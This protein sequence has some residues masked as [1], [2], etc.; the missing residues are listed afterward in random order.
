M[1][2]REL[3]EKY[4][5]FFES[6]GHTQF[7]SGSLIP[8]DVTGRLDE[9]LLF[10]GAG[11]IQFKPY[12]RGAA[13]PTN[14]RLTT[15]QKCVRTGDIE[16]V[17]DDTH[18]TFFEM[19]GNFSFGDYFK[20]EAIR[21]SW[22]FLTSPDWLGLNPARLS[23]TV[24]EADDEAERTWQSC[25]ARHV[26]RL[27]EE[28]NY[29]PAGAFTF[30]PP[31]PCGPNSEMFY[32]IPSDEA[33]P[34]AGY[35][36]DQW[37]KDEA[38]G[39]WVEIWNDVFIQYEW[40]GVA[41]PDTKGYEKTG[42]PE[43]P[44]R[45]I[46][47]GM[48]L[49]RTA[50]VLGG[51]RTVYDTDA[52]APIFVRIAARQGE[53]EATQHAV[54]VAKRVIADHIRTATFC[55]ADGILP[56]NNGRGYVLRRLIRRAILKGERVLK[57]HEAF[58]SEIA[59]GVIESMSVAYPELLERKAVISE[60]LRNE[61]DLFRKTLATGVELLNEELE[62]TNSILDGA[63]AFKL[64][65]T[66]GFPLEVTQELCRERGILVNQDGYDS[67]LKEQQTRSRGAQNLDTVYGGVSVTEEIAMPNAPAESYFFGYSGLQGMGRVVRQ[68][69]QSGKVFVALDRTPFYAESGGQVGD[70]GWIETPVGDFEVTNTTKI[71]RTFW[72][73]LNAEVDNPPKLL[74]E[75]VRASVDVLRRHRIQRNHTATH[76]LHAALRST[77]GT[78]VTQAGSF[79]GP[80]Y[81]RFDFTHGKPLTP[82]Q[83]EAVD[84]IVNRELLSNT[85]VTTYEDLPIDEARA[86]GA[87]A[88]FGEKYGDRVRMV[89]I[90]DFSRELCGG[91]H[92]RTTG[93]IGQFR[94]LSEAS[95]ASGIRRIEAVTGETALE[96]AKQERERLK[97]AAELLKVQ[98]NE[99]L[100]GIE[101]TIDQL[102]QERRKR[103]QIE[104]ELLKSGGANSETIHVEGISLWISNL[105]MIDPK[106]GNSMV[107]EEAA[108]KPNQ[109]TLAAILSEDKV[110]FQCRV[111]T[112]AVQRGAH[113]GNLVKAV[114]AVANGGGGGK[115]E[116][117]SAGGKDVSKVEEALRL[118]ESIL[119]AQ[120]TR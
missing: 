43:L 36:R 19:L 54:L 21:F 85:D 86:K 108:D 13:R 38:A 94:V 41:N 46:D 92:V 63:V 49:E 79:V 51:Y 17:G 32:W 109:V 96:M 8:Y 91:I 81:L 112:E 26:F 116:Y 59:E 1:T 50:F 35:T 62:R 110:T 29:W 103:S 28:T 45:S 6:K 47:T 78:H 102:K 37:L 93:E 34:S 72:H 106:V 55:I 65:D 83:L 18:L 115:A 88:L 60:T 4:I 56:S 87:M 30:G 3:R 27:G 64:Y 68:K 53:T 82:E 84:A 118:A 57:I 111:G 23:F 16:E 117:A 75:S 24:F 120:V 74:E 104:M 14:P 89:E 42:M 52:F 2:V 114:A 67:A 95:A 39:K 10:N 22:E 25:G 12:F 73:E 105:G 101:R 119:R 69:I 48:G 90:G 107:D 77:L 40:Q 44:F 7:P 61:E 70:S 71:S 97:Q 66:F 113:A 9:S 33:P 11:M 76:L 100:S 80:N 5:R 31:G 98:P 15:V 20:E 99:L 58:L